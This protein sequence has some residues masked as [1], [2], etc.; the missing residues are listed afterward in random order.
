MVTIA[1]KSG[2]L[3]WNVETRRWEIVNGDWE[4]ELHCGTVIELLIGAHWIKTRIEHSGGN[5][6]STEPGTQLQRGLEARVPE[7]RF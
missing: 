3:Q 4:F 6:Y 7:R 1:A 2:V 5:Y